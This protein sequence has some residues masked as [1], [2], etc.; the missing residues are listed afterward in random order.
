MKLLVVTRQLVAVLTVLTLATVLNVALASAQDAQ[1]GV[2]NFYSDKY[3]GKKL[4]SGEHYDKSKL[5]AS[6][7][8]LAYGTKVKVTN[9]DNGKSV[10]LT[11]NDRMKKSNP[12]VIDVSRKAAED[13]GFVKAGKAKVKLEVEK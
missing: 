2:A 12:A 8:T 11:I 7:K 9:L 5:T 13:L 3:Q 10:V 1:E 6:H 4:A